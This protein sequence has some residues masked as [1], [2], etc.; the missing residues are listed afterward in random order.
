MKISTLYKVEAERVVQ[1]YH[2]Y[3][4]I[5]KQANQPQVIVQQQAPS[6][7]VDVVEQIQ[8]LKGLQEAGIL[9]EEEFN[10]KKAELL[11]KM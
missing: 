7:N 5:S 10:A 9:T 8:K 6:N 3:R 4:K 1:V 2:E 11:A